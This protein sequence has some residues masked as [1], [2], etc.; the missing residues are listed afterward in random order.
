[1]IFGQYGRA[2]RDIP[3]AILMRTSLGETARVLGP[4]DVEG[5]N[6]YFLDLSSG[7]P[8][9]TFKDW[10]ACVCIADCLHLGIPAIVT[11]SSGNTGN[12]LARYAARHG[13]QLT[14]FYPKESHYKMQPSVQNPLCRFVKVERPE[15]ALKELV[16]KYAR[17]HRLP[18]YP[19]FAHQLEAN[20][21]RAYFLED[22][23][24]HTGVRFDWH[25]QA[26]SSAYGILGFYRGLEELGASYPALLGVQQRG[27]A[28]FHDPPQVDMSHP[29]FE[30]TLFRS[31]PG[32]HLRQKLENVRHRSGGNVVIVDD[33]RLAREAEQHFRAVGLPLQPSRVVSGLHETAPVLALSGVLQ[34]IRDGRIAAGHSVLVVVTGGVGVVPEGPFEPNMVLGPEEEGE[35]DRF[36]LTLGRKLWEPQTTFQ[37]TV[38]R[39]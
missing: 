34:A 35:D 26:L 12:S 30:P 7:A 19:T 11:Q 22:W 27:R 32:D 8:T 4:R 33:G 13:I 29:M 1:M 14:V 9:G 36:V 3:Q 24:R 23:C 6:V 28:P 16:F 38:E 17:V 18:W 15:P 21:L 25:V 5:R 31:D 37:T 2:I 20:K 10:L 39:V